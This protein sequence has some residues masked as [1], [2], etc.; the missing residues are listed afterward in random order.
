MDSSKLET[1][2]T[3]SHPSFGKGIVVDIDVDFYKI[4]FYNTAEVK[5][6][7]RD[8]SGYQVIDGTQQTASTFDIADIEMALENVLYKMNSIDEPVKMADKWLRGNL[9]LEPGDTTLQSKEIP[10]DVFFNKIIMLRER[11]RVLEQKVN[12]HPKLDHSDKLDLQQ[13]ITRCYG[14]M[15]T[16]NVLFRDKHAHFKGEGG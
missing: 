15:T 1:G 14:S 13:Y 16:F 11:L 10:I 2:S 7:A 6:L 9:V 4:Y 8:F 5:E 12:N 3:L